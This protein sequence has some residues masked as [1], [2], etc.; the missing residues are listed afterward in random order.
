MRPTRRQVV[1]ML[2]ALGVIHSPIGTA[3]APAQIALSAQDLKGSLAIQ[4][5]DLDASQSTPVRLALQQNL[6]QFQAVRDLDIADAVP[7]ALIFRP[8]QR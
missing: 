1:Q 6:Q 2:G 5:R 8:R 3:A 7:P 4:G